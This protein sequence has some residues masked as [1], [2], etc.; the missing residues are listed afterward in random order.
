MV[1]T[2]S[3]QRA[4]VEAATEVRYATEWDSGGVGVYLS[5]PDGVIIKQ[6]VE[7]QGADLHAVPRTFEVRDVGVI[8]E[9]E[10]I[11]FPDDKS[12]DLNLVSQH[13]R[14]KGMRKVA[15]ENEKTKERMVVEVPEFEKQRVATSQTVK[16]GERTLIGVFKTS[17]PPDHLELFILKAEVRKIE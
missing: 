17:D 12:I 9:V 8:L 4:V 3:G 10:P 5:Q 7:V 14:L 13:V 16:P 15:V 11:M 2:H 6:P 1:T